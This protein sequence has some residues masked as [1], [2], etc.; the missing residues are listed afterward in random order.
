MVKPVAQSVGMRLVYLADG[1][2]DVEA[3]VDFVFPVFWCEYDSYGKYIV[4][5]L[6]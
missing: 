3:F 1:D 2:I 6:K 4:N 5:F